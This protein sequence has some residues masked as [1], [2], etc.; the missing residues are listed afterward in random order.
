MR[1]ILS[2]LLVLLAACATAADLREHVDVLTS[3]AFA[4]RGAGAAGG[5]ALADTLVAWLTAAGCEP[6]FAGRWEQAVPLHGEGWA[7]QPL[8]GRTGRNVAGLLPGAGD[9]ADRWI[10]VG[11]HHDHLGMVE[12]APDDAPPPAEGTFYPGANDNASGVAA[13]L[14]AVAAVN[15][16]ASPD[17]RGLLVVF[18]D[19]EE[20]G[21]QGSA[22]FAAD[23]PVDLANVDAMINLDT[24]GRLGDGVLHVSGIGTAAALPGLVARADEGAFTIRTAEGG[25]SG[26]DHMIFNTAEIPVVFLFG[27]AYPDYNR[28][29]DTAAT[30]DYAALGAVADF[31]GRL[32]SLLLTTEG[33]LA[34]RMVAGSLREE[35]GAEEGQNRATWLGTLPDFSEGVTGYRLAGVFAGSPAEAAGLQKGDVLVRFAGREVT[36]LATFTRALRSVDPGDPVEVEVRRDGRPL[37]FTVVMGDRAQRR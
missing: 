16:D 17:R 19:G 5:A 33:D 32:V 21:L 34:W 25:W 30:L 1:R 27:G 3:P 4:G 13:V 23:P 14:R 26:S 9:L 15:A 6:A 29:T 22:R 10:I 18:F 37:R 35:D 20:V 31:A 11:A 12:A 36:D 2:T 28:P 24:V 8:D 7:G